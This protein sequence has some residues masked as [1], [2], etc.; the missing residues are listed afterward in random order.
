MDRATG[1]IRGMSFSN[2]NLAADPNPLR[3]ERGGS[4][5]SVTV[6]VA[7]YLLLAFN[8]NFFLKIYEIRGWAGS[9]NTLLF[10]TIFLFV[11]LVFILFLSL[12]GYP[13]LF[14]P[15]AILLIILGSVTCYFMNSY[16]V[17]IEKTMLQNVIET[18]VREGLE[19]LGSGF[20]VWVGLTG[21]LPAWMLYVLPVR[22]GSFA[23][24]LLKKLVVVACE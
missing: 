2:A 15:V 6:M 5:V 4:S 7:V 12:F 9:G 23:S 16:G 18:D 13:W 19:L 11:L 17:M 22:F 21:L 8:L 20:F 1:A 10:I 24:E 14:K 3:K